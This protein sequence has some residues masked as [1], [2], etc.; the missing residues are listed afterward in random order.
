[1]VS[2]VERADNW[3]VVVPR[4]KVSLLLEKEGRILKKIEEYLGKKIHVQILEELEKEKNTI[5]I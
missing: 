1:V 3:H 2:L 4:K 5:T